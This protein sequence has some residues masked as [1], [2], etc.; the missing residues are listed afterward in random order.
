MMNRF[1]KGFGGLFIFMFAVTSAGFADDAQVMTMVKDLEK[2]MNDMQKTIDWQN[3]K[4]K[5]LEQ[6]KGSY[7]PAAPEGGAAAEGYSTKNFETDLKE[8]LGDYGWINGM[9]FGGDLRLR[10]EGR[11]ER[12]SSTS[13]DQNRFRYRLR[14]GFTKTFNEEMKLGFRMVSAPGESASLTRNSTNATFDNQFAFKDIAI[15]T[16]YATYT[17]TWANYG[18]VKGVAVTA[19]KFEN[20]IGGSFMV[21]DG[22]IMPEGIYETAAFK[23]IS[24]DHLNTDVTFLASQFVVEEGSGSEN[25]DAELFAWQVGLDS[26]I[27]GVTDDPVSV[28]NTLTWYDWSDL[29]EP[30]NFGGVAGGNFTAAGTGGTRLATAFN[31]LQLYNEIGFKVD[32]VPATKL[33]FEWLTNTA[34]NA[35]DSLGGGQ[36]N[37]WGIGIKLGKAKDPKTW[38]VGYGYYWLEANSTPGVFTD[39]DFG[40]TDRRGSVLSAKYAF[41]KYLQLVAAAFWTNRITAE[42]LTADEARNLY[43]LDLIWKF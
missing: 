26:K 23:A 9:K 5:T 27:T 33:W 25:D 15:D 20:P 8:K 18:P 41:T 30:G 37:A 7:V 39:S 42:T 38:E 36:D 12:P 29:A 43:Q 28:K 31:V 2:K 10:Y 11:M 4:L 3:Q 21:W 13:N 1:L 40:G 19:G 34:E 32:P 22:D 24:T 16:A 17:P 14:Y 35:D 6:S